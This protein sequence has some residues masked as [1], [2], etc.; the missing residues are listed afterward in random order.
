MHRRYP[1]TEILEM[2]GQAK[3]D[4]STRDEADEVAAETWHCFGVGDS[5]A[6]RSNKVV[7]VLTG[8]V[9]GLLSETDMSRSCACQGQECYKYICAMTGNAITFRVPRSRA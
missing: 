4:P 3:V 2:T 1:D 5:A 8:T 7:F 9:H 6:A